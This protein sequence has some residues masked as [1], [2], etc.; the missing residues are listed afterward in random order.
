[1]P[2][3]K[4]K[5]LTLCVLAL[6]PSLFGAHDAW[7]IGV[8]L[9]SAQVP[10]KDALEAFIMPVVG[11]FAFITESVLYPMLVIVLWMLQYLLTPQFFMQDTMNT[12]LNDIWI[13]S[14]DITNIAF[15][16]MF[17]GV[18]VYTIV[19]A[20]KEFVT[21]KIKHFVLAVILVNFSWFFPRVIIDVSNILTATVYSIPT[22]LPEF[23]CEAREAGGKVPCKVMADPELF[24]SEQQKIQ[25][26]LECEKQN[27]NDS[28]C[29]CYDNIMCYKKITYTQAVQENMP[30]AHATINGLAVSFLKIASLPEIPK[31]IVGQGI[32]ANGPS[33]AKHV[34]MSAL[35][36][37]LFTLFILLPLVALGGAMVIRIL[38]LWVTMAF[39]PF[40]FLGFATSG[41]LGTNLFGMDDYIW[42]HFIQ[43]VFLPVMVAVPMTVGIIMLSAAASITPPE[44]NMTWRIP[45]VQGV[46]DWWTLLW[47]CAALMIIWTGTFAALSKSEYSKGFTDKVKGFGSEIGKAASKLPGFVPVPFPGLPKGMTVGS[48]QNFPRD[49]NTKLDSNLNAMSLMARETNVNTKNKDI[50]EAIH[51][52]QKMKQELIDALKNLQTA[53]PDKRDTHI[54]IINNIIKQKG[55]EGKGLQELRSISGLKFELRDITDALNAAEKAMAK[56][57]D[58]AEKAK[59]ATP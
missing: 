18:A 51:E 5:I 45:L 31:G 28:D 13:L 57:D 38:V 8:P 17:V 39:M 54:E 11:L 14:R 30:I 22:M 1:M 46:E 3:K 40:A 23:K 50:A 12:F 4:Y 19:T 26:K 34:A 44:L 42:K 55:G 6:V 15:A 53:A 16:A 29:R 35:I 25:Y 56:A 27:I 49:I 43:A 41:K 24:P 58:D 47:M 36:S 10:A 9:A 52:D 20:N 7:T 33:I 37:F 2:A 48:L 32:N 59:K 21:G